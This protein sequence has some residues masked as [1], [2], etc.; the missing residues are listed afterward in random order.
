MGDVDFEHLLNMKKTLRKI[1]QVNKYDYEIEPD[2]TEMNIY[3]F[4]EYILEKFANNI[5]DPKLKIGKTERSVLSNVYTDE[6]GNKLCIFLAPDQEKKGVSTKTTSVD[7]VKQFIQ[8]CF[9]NGCYNGILLTEKK[10]SS[11][12]ASRLKKVNL[13]CI[14]DREKGGKIKTCNFIVYIDDDLIDITS[15]MIVPKVLHVYRG[16]EVREFIRTEKL[17]KPETLPIIFH[18]DP[19]AKFY[20]CRNGNIMKLSR[21]FGID[22]TF[23]N[24]Q[25][26]YRYVKYNNKKATKT[27]NKI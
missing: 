23:K 25:I 19:L 22:G 11:E 3:D 13:N 27:T 24:D 15:V 4:K 10:L 1:L 6:S 9:Q 8:L 5:L 16:E 14:D 20:M 2:F 21:P 18:D 17:G 12:A 26:Y 7:T